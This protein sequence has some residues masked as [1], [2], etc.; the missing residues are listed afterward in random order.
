MPGER[1][2]VRHCTDVPDGAWSD[3]D[4]A[5]GDDGG[6]SRGQCE[7]LAVGGRWHGEYIAPSESREDGVCVDDS[8]RLKCRNCR[9]V[10]SGSDGSDYV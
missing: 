10:I 8:T 5:C 3:G 4:T 1:V 9:Y 7:P 2:A 6:R